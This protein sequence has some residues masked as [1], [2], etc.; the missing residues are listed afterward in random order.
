IGLTAAMVRGK[1]RL[2]FSSTAEYAL[3]A[4]VYLVTNREGLRG[5]QEIAAATKVPG[6][7]ISK[8]LKDLVG[9][10]IV[11]SRRGPNGGFALARP[12]DRI[13]VLEVIRAADRFDRI[14]TCPL[15]I[16]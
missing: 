16:P 10:G 4:V 5:S 7:Y 14:L 3:R 9:A 8:I 13:T 11:E 12:P 15:G 2:M 6:G 1:G